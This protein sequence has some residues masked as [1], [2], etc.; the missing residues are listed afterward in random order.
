MKKLCLLLL[1]LVPTGTLTAQG[2]R[3]AWDQLCYN[4]HEPQPTMLNG[5]ESCPMSLPD[6][7]ALT[8]SPRT[9]EF[10]GWFFEQ[11]VD[12]LLR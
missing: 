9:E 8:T 10:V 7:I 6:S 3:T 12:G 2:S 4:T 5:Y 1:L 11:G